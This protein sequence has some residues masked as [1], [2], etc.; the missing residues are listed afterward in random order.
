MDNS[1]KYTFK[2]IAHTY[3][4]KFIHVLGAYN[5]KARCWEFVIRGVSDVRKENYETVDEIAARFV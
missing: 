2:Y 3:K 4:D 1:R 5:D